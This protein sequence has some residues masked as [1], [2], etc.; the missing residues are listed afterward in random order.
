MRIRLILGLSLASMVAFGTSAYFVTKVQDTT[1]PAAG[2]NM[3][4]Q[5]F[6]IQEDIDDAWVKEIKTFPYDLPPGKL[7]PS[8]APAFFHTESN[9]ETSYASDLIGQIAA[10][11]WRCAWLEQSLD[12]GEDDSGSHSRKTEIEQQLASE[13]WES[14]PEVKRN[15]DVDAYLPDMKDYADKVGQSRELVEFQSECH[16]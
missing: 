7:F 16:L 4:P 10:R 13:R 2:S 12:V 11:Y 5:T 9:E 8:T 3:T 15:M 6:I 14:I 1:P